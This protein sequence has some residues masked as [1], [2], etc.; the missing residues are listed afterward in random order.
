MAICL[1]TGQ[2]K[3]NDI[4]DQIQTWA[5]WFL[6]PEGLFPNLQ[7]ARDSCIKLSYPQHLIRP[8]PVALGTKLYE[9]IVT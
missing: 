4:E 9:P 6:S 5:V 3:I 2:M 8:I 7:E 1:E